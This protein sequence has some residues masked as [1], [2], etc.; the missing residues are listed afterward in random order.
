MKNNSGYSYEG[1]DE[2][3]IY[4]EDAKNIYI[5]ENFISSED[6]CEINDFIN[7]GTFVNS[8]YSGHEFPLGALDFSPYENLLRKIHA[9]RDK[10]TDILEKTFDCIMEKAEIDGLTRYAVGDK[11]N[12]HADK[13]CVSWRD[14]ST[15]LY[16]NDA[17][18][19]GELFF[20]QYD[21]T[22]RP[23]AGSL[24]Y[25]PAGGNYAHGVTTV[26]SGVRYVTSTFWKVKKWNSIQYS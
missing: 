8:D 3:E 13:I 14:L 24:I 18:E 17:Y 1:S 15:V 7:L 23:K 11:L 10:M 6:L 19:G 9:Y 21:L 16:Y 4:L 26:N 22:F 12:E 5:I 2:L 25:F 20:S